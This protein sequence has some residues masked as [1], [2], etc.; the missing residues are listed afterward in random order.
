MSMSEKQNMIE[1]A[2]DLG[3]ASNEE[4]AYKYCV[5][6]GYI[7][8]KE[9]VPFLNGLPSL[10]LANG[11]RNGNIFKFSKKHP[12]SKITFEEGHF[13]LGAKFKK[14][15]E[16]KEFIEDEC[17]NG[18]DCG[19]SPRLIPVI[20]FWKGELYN[21]NNPQNS[22]NTTLAKSL[23]K[24]D[25]SHNMI[26]T[27]T[28]KSIPE[29]YEDGPYD[30]SNKDTKIKFMQIVGALIETDDGW[31]PCYISKGLG[32]FDNDSIHKAF[33]K[34]GLPFM[35]QYTLTTEDGPTCL[36][37]NLDSAKKVEQKKLKEVKDLIKQVQDSFNETYNS[38]QEWLKSIRGNGNKSTAVEK[39]EVDDADDEEL[40]ELFGDD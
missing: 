27:K 40:N 12:D 3:Y 26:D 21:S 2:M 34:P 7:S 25:Q 35:Y 36:I 18:I 39:E 30:K 37:Y 38:Q 5:E 31:K 8:D 17:E 6:N 24:Y 23:S 28:K 9:T 14:D 16:T 4:E 20:R 13:Y 10:Q 32:S 33:E 22:V 15:K 29:L 19:E 11:M 1:M